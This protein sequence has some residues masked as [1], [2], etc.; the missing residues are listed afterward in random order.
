MALELKQQLRQGQH[1]IMTPQLQQAVK[2]LQMNTVELQ[3]LIDAELQENPLLDVE[4]P[5]ETQ[6]K[7]AELDAE[8][9]ARYLDDGI[10]QTMTNFSR[11]SDD[12]PSFEA[13]LTRPESLVEHLGWQLRMLNLSEEE[14]NVVAFLIGN[15]DD[16]GYLSIESEA[17]VAEQVGCEPALVSRAIG[18]LQACDPAGVA[19]RDLRECLL[20]Q[21]N[22]R[23]G[24]HALPT[25]IISQCL[26][27]LENKNYPRIARKLGIME[28]E[29]SEAVRKVLQLEPKPGRGFTNDQ[30]PYITPD[31]FVHKIDGDYVITLNDSGLP[32]LRINQF[33]RSVARQKGATAEA[34]EFVQE[35]LSAA[36]GLIKSIHQRQRTIFR[37]TES[38]FKFQRDFLDKGVGYLRPLVLRDVAQDVGLHEGTVGRVTT[39]KYVHTPRGIFELKYFF[40]PGIQRDDGGADM[41]SESVKAEIRNIVQSED[42]RKPYSD[43]AL[44]EMLKERQINIA[45]RTV[46]KYREL[47]GIL[48]SSKRKQIV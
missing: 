48:P 30:A 45:R 40:N 34:K 44:V 1:L 36:T 24:E 9:F 19:A 43:Q 25:R 23:Y 31:I 32:R 26:S 14:H 28:E 21:A 8:A 17:A 2:M 22:R 39:N 12:L 33:Y 42:G 6:E 47:M 18:L 15:L 46:T 41:A 29:V 38:I 35:K 11:P 4:E 16:R 37:V 20:I 7:E 13:S 5:Q 10:E 27:E 3:E